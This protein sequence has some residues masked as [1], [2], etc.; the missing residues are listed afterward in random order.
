[1]LV[2]RVRGVARHGARARGRPGGAGAA[3]CL[4]LLLAPG[5][6]V[7]VAEELP[8]AVATVGR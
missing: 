4:P 5:P 7:L 3:A 2:P 8:A 6:A 1:M